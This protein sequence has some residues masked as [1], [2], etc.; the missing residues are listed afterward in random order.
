MITNKD[1]NDAIVNWVDSKS[2]V[3]WN[4]RIL[5]N[6]PTKD[7]SDYCAEGMENLENSLNKLHEF[8]HD[9]ELPKE[10]KKMFDARKNP[11]CSACMLSAS[12]DYHKDCEIK[13]IE[14]FETEEDAYY[15]GLMTYYGE[16]ENGLG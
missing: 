8:E 7:Q 13:M 10:I 11:A 9:S 12:K 6:N 3:R 15:Y 1:L 2:K 5:L 14:Y 4:T 16:N